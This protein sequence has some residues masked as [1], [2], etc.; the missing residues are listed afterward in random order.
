MYLSISN[1]SEPALAT[2]ARVGVPALVEA[3][4]EVFGLGD[5]AVLD[6]QPTTMSAASAVRPA[7]N[8]DRRTSTNS[9]SVLSTL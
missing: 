4:D 1:W 7:P 5:T 2:L 9:A 8:L 3:V 6:P